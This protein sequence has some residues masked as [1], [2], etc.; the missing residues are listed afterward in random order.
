MRAAVGIADHA[1]HAIAMTVT[2][3]GVL[4]DRRRIE[5]LEGALP[6][7]PHHHEGQN[8]PIA[9]AVAL[10]GRV[11]AAVGSPWQKDHKMA[12][13]AALVASTSSA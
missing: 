10:V 4:L 7:M 13:A 12:M 9:E 5:L 3:D 11:R 6:C 1:G 2:P 8:L